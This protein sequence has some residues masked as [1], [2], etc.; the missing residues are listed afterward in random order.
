VVLLPLLLRGVPLHAE[1]VWSQR[2]L[3]F[4]SK[5]EDAKIVADFSFKNTGKQPVAILSVKSDCSSCTTAEL[6][7]KTYLPGETGVLKATFIFGD[8]VGPQKKHIT[9]ETDDPKNPVTV[10]TLNVLI[11]E[12]LKITP[13]GLFWQTGK[14]RT[15][16]TIQLKVA[17]DLPVKVLRVDSSHEAISAELKT[18]KEG[19]EYQIA[20]QPANVSE[21]AKATLTIRTDF[22]KE[23][24]KVFK[25]YAYIKSPKS[26]SDFLKISPEYVY[27]ER[28]EEPK[29]KTFRVKIESQ[30]PVKIVGVECSDY[31]FFAK[32]R[33]VKADQEYEVVV[34]PRGTGKA[35]KATITIETDLPT[36]RPLFSASAIVK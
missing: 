11:P 36:D 24:P 31:T 7:K 29:P 34:T 5:Q 32:L 2:Q 16:K 27:W 8:R 12:V 20:V 4:T 17:Q 18:I 21:P 22:P 25:A 15:A 26:T 33:P 6:D 14:D 1:L 3:D 30:K 23:N 13:T 10:L 35:A 28:G 19:R 9:V